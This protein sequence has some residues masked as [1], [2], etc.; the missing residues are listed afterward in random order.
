MRVCL[1]FPNVCV[2]TSGFACLQ[3]KIIIAKWKREK[4]TFEIN[5]STT[6]FYVMKIVMNFTNIKSYRTWYA[7][8]S[9][10]ER[11][12]RIIIMPWQ[13][14]ASNDDNRSKQILIIFKSHANFIWRIAVPLSLCYLCVTQVLFKCFVHKEHNQRARWLFICCCCCCCGGSTSLLR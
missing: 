10:T 3:V 1:L 14:W 6:G 8:P 5:P 12:K 13:K 2:C 4:K 11:V 9:T 7:I